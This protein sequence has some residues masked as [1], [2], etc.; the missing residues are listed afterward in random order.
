MLKFLKKTISSFVAVAVLATSI[1][2]AQASTPLVTAATCYTDSAT[3][4]GKNPDCGAVSTPGAQFAYPKL[5][6]EEVGSINL[7]T[8]P[9]TSQVR[10][11]TPSEN[12][13]VQAA[14]LL[15]VDEAELIQTFKTLPANVP[16]V[17]GRYSVWDASLVIDIFK[18]EKTLDEA[19]MFHSVFTP[20]HG[21]IW[22]AAGAYAP[23]SSRRAEAL[24]RNPFE[25]FKSGTGRFTGLTLEAA[26]I[27]VGHAQRYV[28]APTSILA[29]ISSNIRTTTTKSGGLR[30]K[31]TTSYYLDLST[32]WY[33]G[34]PLSQAHKALA[35]VPASYCASN[36][37]GA[38]GTSCSMSEAVAA[39]VAFVEQKGGTFIADVDTSYLGQR[40]KKSWGLLAVVLVVFVAG[41]ASSALASYFATGASVGTGSGAISS[42]LGGTTAASGAGMAGPLTG[43]G[44]KL[45]A[46]SSLGVVGMAATEAALS[47]A[48]MVGVGGA[49]LNSA[50]S[51]GTPAFLSTEKSFKADPIDL[52]NQ[53][54]EYVRA[55]IQKSKERTVFTLEESIPAVTSTVQGHCAANRADCAPGTHGA[56]PRVSTMVT[57]THWKVY[58]D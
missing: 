46:F 10:L 38:A 44:I 34:V 48:V 15:N 39:G 54:D 43:L 20:E 24:G 2:A 40:T 51:I 58:R 25:A 45:G 8:S 11:G 26:Q 41:I 42:V 23:V 9:E 52:N 35:V 7:N 18:V 16:I 33:M 17:L 49:S 32:T 4:Q 56:I 5:T 19:K 50:M 30:K 21:D 57:P 31:I 13:A 53:K 14:E 55:G 47:A 36:P 12:L 28:Q 1:G 37:T 27:A 29:S 22:K 6:W 3:M